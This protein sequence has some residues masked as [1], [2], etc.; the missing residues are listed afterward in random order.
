WGLL[1]LLFYG[2]VSGTPLLV[3]C[4]FFLLSLTL[5]VAAI[6]VV[7][8]RGARQRVFAA[9]MKIPDLISGAFSSRRES[10]RARF[11]LFEEE[12]LEG[13][14]F[15]ITQGAKM[16]SPLLYITLDWFLMLATLYTAFR[17]VHLA[18][19]MHIVVI[20]FSTGVFLSIVNLVP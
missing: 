16:A 7:A 9:I 18:V 12:L 8:S 19:P 1:T 4:F 11:A 20:G 10:L 15:L 2:Q 3:V 5:V 6:A 17:C 14:D 13:V